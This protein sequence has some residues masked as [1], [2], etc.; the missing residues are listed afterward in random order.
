[1]RESIKESI[2]ALL[3]LNEQCSEQLH[4]SIS[5][6]VIAIESKYRDEDSIRRLS[7]N[8]KDWMSQYCIWINNAVNDLTSTI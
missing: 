1:M 4:D 6:L 2:T 3:D 7:F 8:V 5:A